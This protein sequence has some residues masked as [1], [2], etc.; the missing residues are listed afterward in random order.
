M[1]SLIVFVNEGWN[2]GHV[3]I[4]D[5]RAR[6]AYESG[7]YECGTEIR[8]ALFGGEKGIG[9]VVECTRERLVFDVIQTTP[10]LELRPVDLI[11]G[12]SRP[13]TT[14]K[15][16]QAAVMSGARS[17]HL[18]HLASGQKSYLESHLFREV[19]LREEVAKSLAQIWE[20][21]YPAIY[22]H[23]SL[24]RFV[25]GYQ[26]LFEV[27]D[28][29]LKIVA[30]P[31]GSLLTT[32]EGPVPS[33]AIIAVGSEGGWS[34]AEL[35]TF[36]DAG[37]ARVGLGQRVVRV[38]VALLYLLGQTIMLENQLQAGCTSTQ[39]LCVSRGGLI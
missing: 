26:K 28:P 34:E 17:L 3:T 9:R 5:S 15:V 1:N 4:E 2:Q 39:D 8:V 22:V 24:K 21:L 33:S 12:L 30:H 20:G 36:T 23:N 14:K 37:F 16:I 31:G 19:A 35:E 25:Q 38:E 18:V 11:V 32:S 29:T 7:D 6:E 10:S 13:Q 27:S